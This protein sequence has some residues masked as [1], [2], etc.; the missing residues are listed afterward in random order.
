MQFPPDTVRSWH[1]VH[2][3]ERL[4][5]MVA[6]L[7]S[8]CWGHVPILPLGQPRTSDHRGGEAD[9]TLQRVTSQSYLMDNC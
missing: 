6:L 5:R 1:S 7:K 2:G 9:E 3:A 8:E 4:S